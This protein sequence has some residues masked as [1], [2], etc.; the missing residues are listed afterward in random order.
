MRPSDIA[1]ILKRADREPD[2]S[3]RI[4]ASKA[5][6]GTP[7]GGFRFYDTRPDDPNDIVPHEH[8]RE[9][10]GYS[11]VAAW[12]NHVD[13][14]AVN[15]LDTLISAGNR[16]FVR[17]HMLDFGSALG[18]AGDGPAEH[19]EGHEQVIEPSRVA[20]QMLAFGFHVPQWQK[21]DVY[22]SR[23]IG[24]LPRDNTR[25]EPDK[26]KPPVSNPSFL[27]ARPDDKF[28]AARLIVAM[29]DDLL[30]AAVQAGEFDD[31]VSEAFL[32]GALAERRDAIGRT[33]LAAANP[34]VEPALDSAGTLT[35][36]NAA[37]EAG[38]AGAPEGY[39]AV[40]SVFDNATRTS[41]PIGV[42]EGPTPRLDAPPGLPRAP[43]VFIKVELSA[44]GGA[45]L[46]WSR[47]A[48]AYF[49][50]RDGAWRLVGFER[51][52]EE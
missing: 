18:S 15:S 12:L 28:W 14:T 38:V 31:P 36:R 16:A 19:W 29:T 17:H 22:E 32:V 50:Q 13:A 7:L 39:R 46:S 40:W 33:Y 5:L 27:H 48:H 21:T 35:F 30:Q 10:R 2:G 9:L 47:P 1:A 42:T 34:I 41:Q 44:T 45:P 49:R 23:S 8:R 52:P 6:T 11:V 3:Y 25:F 51:S 26:W 4:V 37:V 24:R 43:G 20:R